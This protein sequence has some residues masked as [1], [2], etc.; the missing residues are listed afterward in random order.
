MRSGVTAVVVLNPKEGDQL[1]AA[2]ALPPKKQPRYLLRRRLFWPRSRSVKFDEEKYLLPLPGIE[3]LFL[4]CRPRSL[5][6]MLT[7]LS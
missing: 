7:E 4:G 3:P 1:Y 2:A 6:A 5:L